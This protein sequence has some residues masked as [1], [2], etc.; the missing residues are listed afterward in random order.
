MFSNFF[1][2]VAITPVGFVIPPSYLE[3]FFVT[4][5]KTLSLLG[6]IEKYF[7]DNSFAANFSDHYLIDLQVKK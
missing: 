3:K 2:L 1:D 7:S 6:R 4:K 5:K